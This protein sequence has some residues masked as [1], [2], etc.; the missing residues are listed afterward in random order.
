MNDDLEKRIEGALIGIMS[1]GFNRSLGALEGAGAI[2]LKEMRKEYK[3]NGSRNYDLVTEQLE[4]TAKYGKSSILEIIKD[5]IQK[6]GK[7]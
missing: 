2:D 7:T 5:E 1:D 6:N 4:Y 3:G